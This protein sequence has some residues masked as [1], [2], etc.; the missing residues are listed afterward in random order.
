[1]V[2]ARASL[3]TPL[4]GKDNRFPHPD[5]LP[6]PSRPTAVAWS[7]SSFQ[8]ADDAMACALAE[9]AT[10]LLEEAARGELAISSLAEE[11]RPP[12]ATGGDPSH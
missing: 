12:A 5:K 2:T 3:L 6:P 9:E 4:G 7:T 1:M 10:Q 8:N 11:S